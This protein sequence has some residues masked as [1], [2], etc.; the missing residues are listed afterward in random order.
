MKELSALEFVHSKHVAGNVHQQ[1]SSQM[2]ADFE[3]SVAMVFWHMAD[4]LADLK[5]ELMDNY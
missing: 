4:T 1:D 5:A 3:Q 2:P